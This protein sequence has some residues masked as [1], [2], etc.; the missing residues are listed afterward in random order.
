MYSLEYRGPANSDELCLYLGATQKRTEVS[1]KLGLVRGRL[2]AAPGGG[3]VDQ[4][5]GIPYGQAPVGNLRFADPRPY[6]SYLD[7]RPTVT[8]ARN[9]FM[10]N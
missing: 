3:Q 9:I 7:G 8:L 1:L 10:Y 4:Y 5:L 2:V 6:G